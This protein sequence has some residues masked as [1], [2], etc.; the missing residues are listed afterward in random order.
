MNSLSRSKRAAFS[1]LELMVVLLLLATLTQLGLPRLTSWVEAQKSRA[2]QIRLLQTLSFASQ[3]AL[4]RQL[5]VIV[6]PSRTAAE[7]DRDWSFGQ[8]V[9]VD[10]DYDG[11]LHTLAQ[12][13]LTAPALESEQALFYRGYPR[14][15]WFVYFYPQG[16]LRND[17]GSFWFCQHQQLQWA[18][19]LNQAGERK[20]LIPDANGQIVDT[21]GRALTC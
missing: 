11:K 1:L 3:Q 18:I 17:D 6:C 5:P 2:V 7:C 9:F 19:R 12:R 21:K 20:V 8:M 16:T 4:I 14:Y 13:L 15:H 10:S